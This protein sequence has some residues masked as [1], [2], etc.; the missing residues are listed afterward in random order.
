MQYNTNAQ[1]R[2]G[3]FMIPASPVGAESFL[4]ER[5]A[6]QLQ[7]LSQFTKVLKQ[8]EVKTDNFCLQ[9]RFIQFYKNQL[10][11]LVSNWVHSF[12]YWCFFFVYMGIFFDKI[13]TEHFIYTSLCFTTLITLHFQC[14]SCIMHG[15]YLNSII[16]IRFVIGKEE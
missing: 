5:G 12:L 7:C 15:T 14:I 3:W 16:S 6:V 8:T 2:I 4:I 10:L 9:F 11:H 1:Y 13:I